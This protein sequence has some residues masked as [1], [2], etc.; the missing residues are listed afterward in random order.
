VRNVK[1]KVEAESTF[2]N[3]LNR[4]SG[5][6][7][8]ELNNT[9]KQRDSNPKTASHYLSEKATASNKIEYEERD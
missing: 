5:S 6:S 4:F 8:G 3:D 7:E 9:F 1:G 2:R